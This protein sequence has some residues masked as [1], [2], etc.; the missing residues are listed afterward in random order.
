MLPSD[1]KVPLYGSIRPTLIGPLAC[2]FAPSAAHA[3]SAAVAV[4][5][6]EMG[7]LTS[8]LSCSGGWVFED[9]AAGF[10]DEKLG[11]IAVR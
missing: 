6:S 7:G 10:A 9:E 4:R 8:G 5:A 3:S 1:A 11:L 2:A